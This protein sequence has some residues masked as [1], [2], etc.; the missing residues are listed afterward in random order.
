MPRR[1]EGAAELPAWALVSAEYRAQLAQVERAAIDVAVLLSEALRDERGAWDLVRR[2]T[3]GLFFERLA[4]AQGMRVGRLVELLPELATVLEQAEAVIERLPL[5]DVTPELFGHVH[6]TLVGYGLDDEGALVRTDGRRAFGAHFTPPAMAAQVLRTTMEPL[7]RGL[8]SQEACVPLGQR[9][10]GLRVCDPAVGAGAFLLALVRYL[11]ELIAEHAGPDEVLRD[12]RTAKLHVARYCAHGVDLDEYAVFTARLALALECRA[13]FHFDQNVR[14]GDALVGLTLDQIRAFHWLPTEERCSSAD[15]C[16]DWMLSARAKLGEPD[17][18]AAAPGLRAQLPVREVLYE[19][20]CEDVTM[21]GDVC[22][23][24]F[25]SST[26]TRAREAERLRR[27]DLVERWGEAR[28]GSVGGF[29]ALDAELRALQRSLRE[30]RTPFYWDLAFLETTG[31]E[32]G[33]RSYASAFVGN[34]PFMGG[35]RI[36]STFGTEYLQWLQA[37]HERTAG[38]ADLSAHFFRRAHA[39]LGE[40]GGAIGFI[41]T[42]TIAQGDTRQSGLQYLVDQGMTIYNAWSALPWP[43]NAN[44]TIAIVHLAQ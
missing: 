25:F 29:D 33:N 36:S 3:I 12:L 31:E 24:A 11:G 5:A 40:N 9:L 37:L 27:L 32:R 10:L 6:E 18:I 44:V 38:R 34:P 20:A 35:G 8:A 42:N 41:A 30:R 15:Q 4:L 19:A 22:L 16:V 17:P 13:H 2:Y 26:S 7:V 23:G 43:G 21:L 1:P 14:H 28:Q 39:L